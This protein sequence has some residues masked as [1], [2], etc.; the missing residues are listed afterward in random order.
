M[1]SISK[2][3]KVLTQFKQEKRNFRNKSYRNHI[4]LAD[5]G[6]IVSVVLCNIIPHLMKNKVSQNTATV[7]QKM[8]HDLHNNILN[9]E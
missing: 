6:I 8:G 2:L 9:I 5:N 3:D 1:N 7:F 4:M